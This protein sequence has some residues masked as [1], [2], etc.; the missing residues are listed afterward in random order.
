MM[1]M[2]MMMMM[3]M[4]SIYLKGIPGEEVKHRFSGPWEDSDLILVV[5]NEKFHVHRLILRMNSPVFK[6]MF[7]PQ[8]K[9]AT[10]IEIELPEKK[11]SEVLDLLKQIYFPYIDEKVEITGKFIWLSNEEGFVY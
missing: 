8:F 1:M 2:M 9:E 7:K 11:A 6:A 4:S 5:E 10:C 3:I